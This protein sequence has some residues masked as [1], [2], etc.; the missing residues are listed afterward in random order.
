MITLLNSSGAGVLSASALRP[1]LENA[2]HPAPV[3]L[4]FPDDQRRRADF[5][6]AGK[7]VYLV[8]IGGSGMSGLARMLKSRGA[9]V[10]GS[11]A[12]PSPTTVAL[13][14]DGF[15]VT[16]DQA[17]GTLPDRC[18]LVVMSAA[19]K[20]DHPQAQAAARRAIP[21]LS[22]AQAL[23]ACMLGR[24][25][26][27]IAGT[28]G[29]STTTSMLG[30]CLAAAGLDPTVIIGATCRQLG[31]GFRLGSDTIP[32]GP[33]A[34]RPGL[35]LAESCEFNRSF[36]NYHPTFAAITSVE[37]DHL[38][39]YPDLDAVVESFAH[40]ASL[41][42]PA[43]EGGRLLIAHEGAHRREV[44][45]RTRAAVQTIGFS[46]AADWSVRFDQSSRKTVL[47]GPDR[48]DACEWTNNLP[49]DHNAL[50][51]AYAATL[52]L[53]SGA[54]PGRVGRMLS[55]FRGVDRRAQ[56]MGE[57]PHQFGGVVRV[58]DDYGHHPT[59]VDATLRALRQFEAPEK[60]NGRLI[61][62]F[63][64]HQHSRTR[65][66]LAEFASAFSQADIV[67]VPDIYFV[68]D[69][70]AE[71]QLVSAADLVDRLRARGVQAMHLYPFA[72]IVEQLESIARPG[73]L[74]VVMGAGPVYQIAEGFLAA[75]RRLP[76]K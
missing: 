73:D 29:K 11:D 57:R 46:P 19:I 15:A 65:H 18:D 58:Y 60:R 23:G 52:A 8:G 30:C 36:H 70:E 22:Y 3:P 68:R 24:T 34:A 6:V 16:F 44:T 27:C 71:K 37:A 64:P 69:S 53:W 62:I 17:R 40:F 50:N 13:A 21:T 55:D 43:D 28:H 7:A 56:F 5:D 66:L 31:G 35:L 2:V 49:G 72:A 51:G 32:A 59:E 4:P 54:D 47:V 74:V 14:A 76:G 38:D 75:A 20:P 48:R 67:I 41:I 1:G 33:L 42:R 10:S 9:A 61:C 25:A 39:V 26:I 63:Q 45:A 12:D